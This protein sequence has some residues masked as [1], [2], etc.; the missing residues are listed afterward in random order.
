MSFHFDPFAELSQR[1]KT[2]ANNGIDYKD[3]AKTAYRVFCKSSEISVGEHLDPEWIDVAA[4][5]CQIV[6]LPESEQAELNISAKKFAKTLY[7]QLVIAN[8][9]VPNW[10]DE[11]QIIQIAWEATGRHLANLIDSDGAQNFQELEDRI[12]GWAREKVHGQQLVMS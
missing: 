10:E 3:L 11:S 12:V 9:K 7:T 8:D 2:S 6:D 4:R 5:A 1:S